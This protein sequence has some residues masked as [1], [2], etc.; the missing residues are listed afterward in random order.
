MPQM[1]PRA[2]CFKERSLQQ[3]LSR[4]VATQHQGGRVGEGWDEAEK[5]KSK[6]NR[7]KRESRE[8]K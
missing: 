5:T 3:L 8:Q 1:T 2:V 7:G 4:Q 6:G